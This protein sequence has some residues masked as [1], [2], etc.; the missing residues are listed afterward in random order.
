MGSY[1]GEWNLMMAA[2]CLVLAPVWLD[3]PL[4]RSILLRVAAMSVEKAKNRR[5][6]MHLRGNV[7]Y[8]T[9]ENF[10]EKKAYKSSTF[11]S[12]V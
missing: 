1:R 3:L 12:T 7:I 4:V 10:L 5:K 6:T 8:N 11:Q 9:W 2:A